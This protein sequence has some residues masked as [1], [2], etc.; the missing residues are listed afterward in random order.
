[1]KS[2]E[3]EFLIYICQRN[4]KFYRNFRKIIELAIKQAYKVAL[5]SYKKLYFFYR[6]LMFCVKDRENYFF[7]FIRLQM[8]SRIHWNFFLLQNSNQYRQLHKLSA[9]AS[10]FFWLIMNVVFIRKFSK[11][12]SVSHQARLY[13]VYSLLSKVFLVI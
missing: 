2:C 3:S 8:I 1:M 7:L 10:I 6:D 13:W 12:F 11:V 4:Q 5:S 9:I